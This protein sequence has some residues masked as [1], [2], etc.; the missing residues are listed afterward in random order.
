LLGRD[1]E[2]ELVPFVRDAGV[3]VF[4]WSPLAGGFLTGKY[5]REN[6]RGDEGRLTSFDML[7]YDKE[8]GYQ[9]IDRLRSI[10]AAHGASPAQVAIAWVLSKPFVSSVLLGAN[11]LAQLEDNLGAGNLKLRPQDLASLDEFTAPTLTYP[12]YFNARVVDEPL[13]KALAL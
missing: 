10:A 2:H 1:I 13:R 7:P 6:P 12:T 4:V 5:T 8:K 11:K 9:L 3:G